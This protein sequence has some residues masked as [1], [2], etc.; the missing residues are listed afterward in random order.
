MVC[1]SLFP[2]ANPH[3][4]IEKVILQQGFCKPFKRG[5]LAWHGHEGDLDRC[6]ACRHDDSIVPVLVGFVVHVGELIQL[7][8]AIV[9]EVWQHS[10]P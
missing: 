4:A 9:C 7:V 1:V 8:V 10:N 5:N 6:I 3:S 2:C